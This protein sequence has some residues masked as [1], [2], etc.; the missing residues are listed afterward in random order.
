MALNREY[1]IPLFF[2]SK[3]EAILKNELDKYQ[4]QILYG[5]RF[6]HLLSNVDKGKAVKIVIEGYKDRLRQPDLKSI[7]LGDSLNDFAMLSV[8]DLAIL[9]KKYDGSYERSEIIK[10]V[11]YSPGIGPKGWNQSVL[12]IL[13][14]GGKNE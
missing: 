14:D 11:I 1:S 5:G 6:M 3:A 10:H 13:Q 7:A 12:K 4:L 8:T 9:V 2:D